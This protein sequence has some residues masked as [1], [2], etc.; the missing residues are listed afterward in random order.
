MLDQDV[1]QSAALDIRQPEDPLGEGP[2]DEE[3]MSACL[4]VAHHDRVNTSGVLALEPLQATGPV[5]RTRIKKIG[6]E[7]GNTVVERLQ[8]LDCRLQAL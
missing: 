8:A 5:R 6:G 7:V 4:G 1:Q 3:R 2:V